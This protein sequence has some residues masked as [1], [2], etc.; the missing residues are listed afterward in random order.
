MNQQLHS[1]LAASEALREAVLGTSVGDAECAS[2][3]ATWRNGANNSKEIF[4]DQAFRRAGDGVRSQ[5]INK[6]L[7]DLNM[8]TLSQITLANAQI[9]AAEYRQAEL[10]L[11]NDEEFDDLISRAVDHVSRTKRRFEMWNQ[12]MAPMGLSAT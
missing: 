9:I 4:G 3:A 1:P 10:D 12:R 6:G 7:V 2:L 8:L 5:P 11:L